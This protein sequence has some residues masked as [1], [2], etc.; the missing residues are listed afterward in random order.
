[1]ILL[2]WSFHNHVVYIDLKVSPY[3]LKK[4]CIWHSLVGGSSVLEN[5]WYNLIILVTIVCNEIYFGHVYKIHL[6]LIVS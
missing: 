5:K 2:I 1:M 4:H 3:M 6:D